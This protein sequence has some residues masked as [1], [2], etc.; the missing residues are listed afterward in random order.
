MMSHAKVLA[1]HP[2]PYHK[3]QPLLITCHLIAEKSTY[4]SAI[5]VD[6]PALKK[7]LLIYCNT[8]LTVSYTAYLE[9]KTAPI[10]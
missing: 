5:V 1:S 7:Y 4:G 10:Y 6:F 3:E 8:H 2:H 9:Q